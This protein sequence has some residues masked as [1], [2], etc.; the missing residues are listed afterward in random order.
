MRQIW[1]TIETVETPDGPLELRRRG[2]RDA[3]ITIAG[4]VLMSSHSTRSEEALAQLVCSSLADR[5]EP[6]VLVGGLGLGK[7]NRA[8]WV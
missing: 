4:R 8:T 7:I 5:P 3:L 6:R 2:D 1:K